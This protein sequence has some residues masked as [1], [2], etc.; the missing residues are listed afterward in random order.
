MLSVLKQEVCVLAKKVRREDLQPEQWVLEQALQTEAAAKVQRDGDGVVAV[1]SRTG[2]AVHHGQ[3]G[4]QTDEEI[5][6]GGGELGVRSHLQCRQSPVWFVE[7]EPASP[8][9]H[10][11]I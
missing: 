1:G 6:D 3:A 10:Q 8:L 4:V 2:A 9:V 7:C 5:P 11:R